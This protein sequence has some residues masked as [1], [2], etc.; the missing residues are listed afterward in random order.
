MITKKENST[1]VRAIICGIFLLAFNPVAKGEQRFIDN[2][3]GTVTDNQLG[4]MW[5]KS[6]NQKDIGW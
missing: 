5:A 2:R 3:D 6:D 4:V 1:A